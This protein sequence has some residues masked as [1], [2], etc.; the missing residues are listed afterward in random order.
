MGVPVRSTMKLLIAA[1]V[2]TVCAF[3]APTQ[4]VENDAIVPET[5]AVQLTDTIADLKSQFAELQAQA[6]VGVEVTPG[7]KTTIDKMVTM[8]EERIEPAI[9]D[10]HSADQSDMNTLM[11]SVQTHNNAWDEKNALLQADAN[12]VRGLIDAEQAASKKWETDAADFTTKQNHYLDQYGKQTNTCCQRDNAAVTDIHYVPAYASCDYKKQD[13]SGACA[14]VARKAVSDVVA[15]AFT[16]GLSTYRGLRKS[17][18]DLTDSMN[19]ADGAT[20]NQFDQCGAS[21]NAET[22]AAA[23]AASEQ[24]RMQGEW[25]DATEAYHTEYAALTKA[26]DDRKT[27]VESDEKDRVSEWGAV[28]TIKC[29]L[30]NYKEGGTFDSASEKKC[31]ESIVTTGVVDIGYPARVPEKTPTLEPFEDQADDSAYENTC[32]S[33]T[34]GPDFNCVVTEARAVPECPH[35]QPDLLTH[36]HVEGPWDIQVEG[37]SWTLTDS[38]SH[39]AA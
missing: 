24:K 34:P 8:V 33:R 35:A 7:V 19:S 1:A 14:D 9:K 11:A 5:V 15:D 39:T 20:K 37:Q 30:L 26:Y 3:A 38:A 29:M 2:L 27:V 16:T 21:K 25:D 31:R 23:L 12:N 4:F 28:Q 18:Q 32:D 13:T 36:T 10:A 6:K 22:A 17:C